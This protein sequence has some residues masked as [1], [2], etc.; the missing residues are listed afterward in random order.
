LRAVI[1]KTAGEIG[2]LRGSPL[3]NAPSLSGN[4]LK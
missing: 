3:G 4:L 1:L 2:R